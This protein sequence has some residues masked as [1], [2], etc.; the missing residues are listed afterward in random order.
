MTRGG[1][2]KRSLKGLCAAVEAQDVDGPGGA[3][4]NNRIESW[5]YRWSVSRW[6]ALIEVQDTRLRWMKISGAD[7]HRRIDS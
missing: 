1:S 7:K 3:L 5:D 6:P 4:A 2:R